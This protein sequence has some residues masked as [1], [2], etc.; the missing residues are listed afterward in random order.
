M[1]VKQGSPLL[2]SLQ[3]RN[4]AFILQKD[5]RTIITRTVLNTNNISKLPYLNVGLKFGAL[6]ILRRKHAKLVT[7]KVIKYVMVT[8]LAQSIN[9]YISIMNTNPTRRAYLAMELISIK[10]VNCES[11]KVNRIAIVGSSLDFVP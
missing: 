9:P 10:S 11:K 7:Q 6:P 4:F 1:V 8:K 3:I 5:Q 2:W